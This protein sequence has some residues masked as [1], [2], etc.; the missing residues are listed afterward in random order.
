VAL[1]WHNF[2]ADALLHETIYAR[3]SKD[4]QLVSNPNQGPVGKGGPYYLSF[5]HQFHEI[6]GGIDMEHDGTAQA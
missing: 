2:D 1:Q 3:L 5:G 4:F 6:H